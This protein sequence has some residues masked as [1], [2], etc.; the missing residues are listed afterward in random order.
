MEGL[1]TWIN[2]GRYLSHE[3][4]N[5][6]IELMA[7]HILR[8]L[9]ADIKTAKWFSII[10]DE[11]QDISGHEQ[12][13]MSVRWVSSS[14]EISEDL[15]GFFQVDVTDAATLSAVI[16]DLLLRCNI[17]L[18]D[19]RGQ[20]YDGASNM[21]GAL[22]GVATR[23]KQ[24]EPR[25]HFIHCA[26]HCLNLCLQE[27]TRQCLCL[28]D[29][30]SLAKGIYNILSSSPKRLARFNV[31]K[32]QLHCASP[33][34][35]PICQTRWTVRTSAFNSI[36]K[37]YSVVLEALTEIS[38]SHVD[39]SSKA[40]GFVALME[41]FSTYFGLKFAF[42][43]FGAT[44]Q[45]STSLQYKDNNAQEAL[46]IVTAA[47]HFLKRQRNDAAFHSFYQSVVSEATEFTYDPVLPRQKKLPK[48]IDDGASSHTYSTPEEI[49]RHQY[50]KAIDLLTAEIQRRFDQPT[51]TLLQ[52][53]EKV[54]I[55]SC[56]GESVQ[57]SSSF[58]KLCESD[59]EMDMLKILLLMLPDVIL[60]A[61]KEYTIGIK[62]VTTVKTLC[63][64]FNVCKFPKTMLSEVDRLVRLYLTIP[65]TTCTSERSFSTLR[66]LKSYPRSTIKD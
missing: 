27:C 49:Y 54:L 56:N 44:E 32:E 3:I 18:H 8:N 25:A 28:R 52:E 33:G 2:S 46:S 7:H 36:I 64:V 38:E 4:V 61:N 11:T 10:A 13:A 15:I 50:Y 6:I 63:E 31:L 29:A 65:L 48:R 57:L 37:N 59:L 21:S 35:K 58:Q 51:F 1:Q 9:L 26:A 20:A 19:C 34:L 14:Y 22:T 16:K 42:L 24:E 40:A 17:S 41:K 43:L 60:T 23:L 39:A 45:A 47:V 12:F 53:I 30:L 62:Q 55:D 66:R 5:E